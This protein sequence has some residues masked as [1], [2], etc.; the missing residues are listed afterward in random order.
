VEQQRTGMWMLTAS[1][2]LFWPL[3]PRASEIEIDDIA[4]HL[5]NTGRWNGGC[6]VFYSVAQHSL[7]VANLLQAQGQPHH[8]VLWGL[9]HDAA[10]AYVSDLATPLKR[11]LPGYA[12]IEKRVLD[13]VAKRF[14]LPFQMPAE[15]KHAD[16]VLLATELRDLMPA[17]PEPWP[18]PLPEPLN[19]ELVP[20]APEAAREQF[21]ACFNWLRS[22]R[23]PLTSSRGMGRT[24][25]RGI[26]G[27]PWH[28]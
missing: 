14:H 22:N 8:V 28:G 7:E 10:E 25:R 13:E 18:T 12:S 1:G 27:G 15:V 19:R 9:L 16:A 11:S 3:D 21:L 24:F 4:H 26:G 5:A 2:R 23:G 17:S 6:R 20:R